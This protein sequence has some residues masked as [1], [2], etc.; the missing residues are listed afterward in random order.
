MSFSL[1]KKKKS[2]TVTGPAYLVAGP[3]QTEKVLFCVLCL[4]KVLSG[5]V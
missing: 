2:V 3:A 1:F 5:M 4:F